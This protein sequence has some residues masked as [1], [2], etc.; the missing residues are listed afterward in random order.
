MK[1]DLA[2]V[3]AIGVLA[4]IGADLAH[5]V[6]GHGIGL[7]LSGGRAGILTTTRLISDTPRPGQSWRIFDLG[8]PAGNLTWAG[9]CL[10]LQR[11]QRGAAPH[12]RL[13]LWASA[14]FSLFWEF[15]YLMKCG[16]TGS[17]DYMALITG[18]GPA[19][20]WRAALFFA[21]LIPYR[22]AIRLLAS[23]LHFVARSAEPSWRSRVT[24]V[25]WALYFAGGLAACS[26][27]ILDPRGPGEIFN[28][29]ALTS[30][31][32]CLGLV[33]V[34]GYFASYP[35]KSLAVSDSTTRS[36]PITALAV[37][38][39]LLFVLGLGPGIPVSV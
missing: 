8:G 39:L 29:G 22:A 5:E 33:F 17:G 28:S 19:G 24:R 21:G 14:M 15:G 30:F 7:L 32:A 2:T 4:F 13:F 36:A 1:D 3:I 16:V 23:D 20:V 38:A 26:G 27:A 9:L 6:V 37:I 31:V 25:L 34:P 35:D 18:L 10:V 12:R 11:F